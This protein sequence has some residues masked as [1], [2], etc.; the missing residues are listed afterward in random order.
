MGVS[1]Q[2]F[3]SLTIGVDERTGDLREAA[4]PFGSKLNPRSDQPTGTP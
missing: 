2:R 4:P 1:E 3:Q